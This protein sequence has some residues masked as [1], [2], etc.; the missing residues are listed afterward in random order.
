MA[1]RNRRTGTILQVDG[2]ASASTASAGTAIVRIVNGINA[3]LAVDLTRHGHITIQGK[4]IIPCPTTVFKDLGIDTHKVEDIHVAATADEFKTFE[5]QGVG[6]RFVMIGCDALIINREDCRS[7]QTSQQVSSRGRT[8]DVV[9][10][11]KARADRKFRP[12]KA[13]EGAQGGQQNTTA[14]CIGTEVQRVI[15]GAAIHGT[16]QGGTIGEHEGI[17]MGTSGQVLER[18]AAV[19]DKVRAIQDR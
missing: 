13:N 19:G 11:V 7:V 4:D 3:T 5:G 6:S 9:D 16:R 12:C 8:K 1:S 10:I 14:S 17:I 18:V 2:H 15:A